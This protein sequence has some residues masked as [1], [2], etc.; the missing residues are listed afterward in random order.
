M[1]SYTAT[2]FLPFTPRQLFDLAANVAEY[3]E[4]VPL[5]Q[6]AE[7]ENHQTDENGRQTFDAA[8]IVAYE[9]LHV[10]EQFVSHVTADPESMTVTAISDQGPVKLLKSEW[11]FKEARRGGSRV[12]FTVDYEM[13]SMPLQLLMKAAMGKVTDKVVSAFERRAFERYGD[14]RE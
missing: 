10:R 4:F 13:R 2:R 3:P 5:C 11:A 6:V 14:E 8:L 7:I 12:H 9:K 1:A